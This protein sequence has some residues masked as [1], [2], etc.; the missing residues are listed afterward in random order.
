MLGAAVEFLV[1]EGGVD[2]SVR[3]LL[4]VRVVGVAEVK[5]ERLQRPVTDVEGRTAEELGLAHQ[6]ERRVAGNAVFCVVLDDGCADVAVVA[7]EIGAAE[8][9]AGAPEERIVLGAERRVVTVGIALEAVGM[10][11]KRTGGSVHETRRLH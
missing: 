6:D 5:V 9:H 3:V 4:L 8:R 7:E 2:R 10:Q 1:L 11:R